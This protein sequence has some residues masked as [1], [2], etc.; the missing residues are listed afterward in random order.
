MERDAV[1]IRCDGN[2]NGPE[3]GAPEKKTLSFKYF[4]GKNN[5]GYLES[6]YFPYKGKVTQPN[7]QSPVVAVQVNG[8]EVNF[9]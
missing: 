2:Y 7:Y 1:Y 5:D 8:L 4:G 9:F 6:K 3:E